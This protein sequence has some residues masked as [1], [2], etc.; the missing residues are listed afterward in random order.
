MCMYNRCSDILKHVHALYIKFDHTC[1]W[2]WWWWWVKHPSL[3]WW[4]RWFRHIH[5]CGHMLLCML[6]PILQVRFLHQRIQSSTTSEDD[7]CACPKIWPSPKVHKSICS[8]NRNQQSLFHCHSYCWV[9]PYSRTKWFG[10]SEGSSNYISQ[11]IINV[12]VIPAT[13]LTITCRW[14]S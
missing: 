4:K 10:L 3:F 9:Y 6:L 12:Q 5:L 7:D 11:E 13:P 2:R 8:Y 1:R 14:C